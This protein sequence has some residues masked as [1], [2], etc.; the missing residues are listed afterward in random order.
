[1]ADN[2]FAIEFGEKFIKIADLKKINNKYKVDYIGKIDLINNFYTS[3]LEKISED[4]ANEIKKIIDALGI[5]KKNVIVSLNNNLAYHQIIEMPVLKEKELISA[6]KY[7][8][9]Q[10]IPMPI[11]EVNID[12]EIVKEDEK[13]KKMLIL[14]VAASKKII[15][16]IQNTIELVGLIPEAIETN[17]SS[18]SR[19]IN[20]FYKEI[21]SYYKS[22]DLMVIDFDY[23]SSTFSYFDEEFL[24]LKKAHV[25]SIGYQLFLKDL[26]VNLNLDEK[27]S[28]DFLNNY[29]LNEQ[30]SY[31][32]EKIISPLIKEFV[33]EINKFTLSKKP[34]IIL[35]SGEIIYFPELTSLIKKMIPDIKI[36]ILNPGFFLEKNSLVEAIFQEMPLY[37]SVIGTNLR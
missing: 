25:S 21:L 11:D 22:N 4:Q 1:M 9:D 8:A 31:P 14:I 17:L 18:S 12:L 3:D 32:I 23:F 27:K 16:K 26:F 35:F 10:F 24:I 13:N 20:Y 5:N 36:E 15:E 30:S 2:F 37:L 33:L 28:A 7:Q 29:R 6:I 19:F 34:S